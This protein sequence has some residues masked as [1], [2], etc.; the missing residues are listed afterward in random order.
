LPVTRRFR[1]WFRGRS[2]VLGPQLDTFLVCAASGVIVNR[3][4]LIVT[5]YPQI[6]GRQPGA[7]HISHA[8]YGPFA[9]M[10][11]VALTISFLNP[12]VRWF[13][14]IVGGLGFGWFVD[15]LGKFVSNAGYLYR[16]ALA[17]IYVTFVLMFLGFR[18]LASHAYTADDAVVNAIESLKSAALG[19]L[20]DAQRQQALL[21][22]DAAAPS[23]AFA[24][25]V[26][27]LL[28]E[29]PSWPPRPPSRIRQLRTSVR[30]R[31][32]A[33]SHRR[34]FV[35]VIDVFFLVFATSSL[36]SVIGLSLDGPGIRR[37]SER[38]ATAAASVAGI[39]VVV[40]MWKLRRSRQAA[41]GWFD[42]ALLVH[43]L[44][45][46]VYL[47]HDQQFAAVIGLAVD[48]A[49]WA[50]LRSAMAVE[51]QRERAERGSGQAP[52]PAAGA[53]T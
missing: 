40:G 20:D 41:F 51:E 53:T 22:F 32:V 25:R 2:Y 15:E 44:V 49:V 1:E 43:I 47:F 7:I 5:G 46:Q 24:A 42:R 23:G 39:L 9:M 33:W 38:V 4:F 18:A 6:G 10:I 19:S 50:M 11:A 8:I 36:G 13:L 12:A 26:R 14:A 16:P 30:A 35:V 45:V 31:Y 3:V 29:A 21:R 34:S 27:A 17:L 48:L 28:D 37:P 52:V